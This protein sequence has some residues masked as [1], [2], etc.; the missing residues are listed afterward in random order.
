MADFAEYGGKRFP[1]QGFTLDQAKSIMAR[2][3][4]ELAEPKIETKKDGEDTIHVFTKQAGRKGRG[5]VSSLSPCVT[6]QIQV[7][8]RGARARRLSGRLTRWAET[9][10][11]PRRELTDEELL[12]LADRKNVAQLRDRLSILAPDIEADGAMLL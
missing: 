2:H 10:R 5:R 3:F 9:G 6:A 11:A 12:P 1:M 4:P 7:N 8:L